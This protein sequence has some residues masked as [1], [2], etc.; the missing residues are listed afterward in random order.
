MDELNHLVILTFWMKDVLTALRLE[1]GTWPDEKD[2]SLPR[3]SRATH[4]VWAPSAGQ[5]RQGRNGNKAEA[6][7]GKSGLIHLLTNPKPTIPEGPWTVFS[8]P[9]ANGMTGFRVRGYAR[10]HIER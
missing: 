4:D 8:V 10:L 3:F 1:D 7:D 2:S 5:S 9:C 6:F